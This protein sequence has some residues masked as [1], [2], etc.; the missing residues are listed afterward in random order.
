MHRATK[1]CRHNG[2]IRERQDERIR[3]MQ[4]TLSIVR[5]SCRSSLLEV[6][7]YIR[8]RKH[9]TQNLK[10]AQWTELQ[11]PELETCV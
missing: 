9:H 4:P 6:V 5:K 7:S 11:F 10:A 2:I 8:S 1:E 3:N